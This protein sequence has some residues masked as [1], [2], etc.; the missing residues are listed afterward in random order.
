MKT[1]TMLIGPCTGT[2]G[3]YTVSGN[4]WQEPG[5][6]KYWEITAPGNGSNEHL[7]FFDNSFWTTRFE[8]EGFGPNS[9]LLTEYDKVAKIPIQAAEKAMRE[10]IST[11]EK[12]AETT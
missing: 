2:F 4:L 5:G 6:R 7:L 12:E 3:D 11:W 10:A 8:R 1:R 9:T